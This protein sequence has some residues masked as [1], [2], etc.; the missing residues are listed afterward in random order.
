MTLHT[1][2]QGTYDY[3]TVPLQ[4][5]L[6][7]GALYQHLFCYGLI[8]NGLKQAKF[9]CVAWANSPGDCGQLPIHHLP[10]LLQILLIPATQFLQLIP[11]SG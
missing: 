3:L 1:V 7:L 5:Q 6:G 10:P 2:P 8:L 9:A 4:L 11:I